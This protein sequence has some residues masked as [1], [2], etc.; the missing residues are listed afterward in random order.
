MTACHIDKAC[1]V[2]AECTAKAVE[3]A[4]KKAKPE[5][6]QNEDGTWPT[7]YCVDCD[8]EIEK[9]RLL[10]GKVRCIACQTKLEK[11]RKRYGY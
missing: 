11:K 3:A 1:E 9:P 7:L 2:E 10:L 6:V 4:M 8:E 5:Q